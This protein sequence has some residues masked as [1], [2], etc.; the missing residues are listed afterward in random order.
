MPNATAPLD[1]NTPMKFHGMRIDH[2]RDG[3]CGVMKSVHKFKAQ[4]RQE[5]YAQENKRHDFRGMDLREV[6]DQVDPHIDESDDDRHPEN[7][8]A[9]FGGPSSPTGQFPF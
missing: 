2:R 6:G 4:R 3:V 5:R 1:T 8:H 7:A 9:N